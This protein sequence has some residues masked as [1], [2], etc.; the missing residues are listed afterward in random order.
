MLLFFEYEYPSYKS[1]WIMGVASE[2]FLIR[3]SFFIPPKSYF[4]F[5]KNKRKN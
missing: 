4:L 1:M 2:I 5:F 3:S